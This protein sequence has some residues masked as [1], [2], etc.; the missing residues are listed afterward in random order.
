MAGII[1]TILA[2]I[3][4]VLGAG[5]GLAKFAKPWH[6]RDQQ[7]FERFIERVL[8]G[9]ANDLE[10][11]GFLSVAVHHSEFLEQVRLQILA[12]EAKHWKGAG[13][14]P[15]LLTKAG[16]AELEAILETLKAHAEREF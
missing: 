2:T 9:K 10:W 16:R 7:A 4:V 12:I 8:A 13:R 3:I 15:Y 1:V 14:N 11:S 5:V 6:R